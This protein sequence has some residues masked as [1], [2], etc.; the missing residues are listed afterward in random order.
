[1]TAKLES[2]RVIKLLGQGSFGKVYLVQNRINNW[3]N[4][5]QREK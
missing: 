1:M 4:Q 2:F 3:Q 5:K